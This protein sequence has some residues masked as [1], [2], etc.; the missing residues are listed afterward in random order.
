M[1]G[2][3]GDVL[4]FAY[5]S[6]LDFAQMK[7]RCPSARFAGVAKLPGRRLAFTRWSGGRKG[8]VADAVADPA[9][10]VWGVVYEI[11]A[12][13]LEVLDRCEGFTPGGTGNAYLRQQCT[14]WLNGDPQRAVAAEVYFAVPQENPGLPSRDYRDQILR[15]AREWGLPQDYIEQDLE[16]IETQ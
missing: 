14:V 11:T 9:G 6:N 10:E 5:G 3:M 8:A 1:L 7:G 15:G 13:D 4:Y 12:E 16:T 2:T